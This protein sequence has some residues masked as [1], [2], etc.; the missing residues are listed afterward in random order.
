MKHRCDNCGVEWDLEDLQPIKDLHQRVDPG[1]VMPSGECP[2][3]GALCYPEK[4]RRK[5]PGHLGCAAYPN[6]DVDPNGCSVVMGSDMEWY[7]HRD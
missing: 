3:C 7:G 5:R 1:G 2:D 6:C 4:K